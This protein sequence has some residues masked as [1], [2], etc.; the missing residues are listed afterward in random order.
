MQS[1][2]ASDP[3]SVGLSADEASTS[4]IFT[5]FMS[6]LKQLALKAQ[7]NVDGFM[8]GV[9]NQMKVLAQKL[10][11]P[12]PATPTYGE[13]TTTKMTPSAKSIQQMSEENAWENEPST[14]MTAEEE[15]GFRAWYAKQTNNYTTNVGSDLDQARADY[16]AEVK[17]TTP[18]EMTQQY[19]L[20]QEIP[21]ASES[22]QAAPEIA[23]SEADTEVEKLERIFI[24]YINK[25][26]QSLRQVLKR[27]SRQM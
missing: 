19:K 6:S 18:I 1:K 13:Y 3:G 23:A 14:S 9:Q 25:V 16:A 20:P 11:K 24:R 7:G 17:P 10:G 2:I 8:N 15:Q 27:L 4:F 5:N 22:A 26:F 12:A 21:F